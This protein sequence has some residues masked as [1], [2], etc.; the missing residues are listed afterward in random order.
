[1][2][3]LRQKD[4]SS[5]SDSNQKGYIL[6]TTALLLIPLMIFAAFAVDVGAWYAEADKNQRAADAAALAAVIEMPDLN[7]AGAKALSIVQENGYPNAV[8]VPIT[9]PTTDFD[10]TVTVPQVKVERRDDDA[11]L[12]T[13]L[14]KGEV[15]FGGVVLN[16]TV[17][18]TRFAGA[19]YNLPV[20][21]GSPKNIIGYGLS[22]YGGITVAQQSG[23]FLTQGG[24]CARTADGDL[25]ASPYEQ[26]TDSGG[27]DHVNFNG[28]SDAVLDNLE[29][30]NGGSPTY[31]QA[32][33]YIAG[34]GAGG[35]STIV[36]ND[37]F[38]RN[39][40]TYVVDIPPHGASA[41]YSV[42]LHAFDAPWCYDLWVWTGSW[43]VPTPA[44]VRPLPDDRI[45]SHSGG[46]W[47]ISNNGNWQPFDPANDI[48]W[49]AVNELTFTVTEDTGS[50]L[51]RDDDTFIGTWNPPQPQTLNGM[52]AQ[53]NTAVC[54]SWDQISNASFT[55]S[56]FASDQFE[57]RRLYIEVQSSEARLGGFNQGSNYYALQARKNGA[58]T[59]CDSR[60]DA[61]CPT[62]TGLERLP[63]RAN[64]GATPSTF[65]LA[66]IGP[67]FE[68]KTLELSL[69][70]TGEG[71]DYIQIIGPS[72]QPLDFTWEVDD[73]G[74][75]TAYG[76]NDN[77]PAEG[78]AGDKRLSVSTILPA[79]QLK[80]A[81]WSTEVNAGSRFR[82]QGRE[83]KIFVDLNEADI[84]WSTAVDNWFRVRYTPQ[85]GVDVTD[86]STWG[87]QVIGDPVRLTE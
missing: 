72:G 30:L 50:R 78:P 63:I 6:A 71:M 10:P 29:T 13:I 69:Y 60:S 58:Q 3:L 87:V 41:Q 62:I 53:Q 4:N 44:G 55:S 49:R 8:L 65:F 76:A 81:S 38:N 83:L 22:G 28:C 20:P 2:A 48:G 21:L 43:N 51:T 64:G 12:V 5:S 54:Q 19:D 79:D 57:S 26:V 1:M 7:R 23:L 34:L 24:R 85:T 40:Y 59:V 52:D 45:F 32:D 15:Y 37:G 68:G 39:G 67:E 77:N 25:R 56:T 66:D 46:I 42:S 80:F 47:S 61:L 17:D 75:M 27:T 31:A 14:S 35:G 33:A 84:Q 36:P 70:D 73:A 18:I 11:I 82:F 74:Q 9:T 16:D 86:V